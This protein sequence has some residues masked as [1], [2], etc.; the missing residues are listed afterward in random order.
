MARR[1]SIQIWFTPDVC[2]LT[3]TF[4]DWPWPKGWNIHQETASGL[5]HS[6][7][8][9]SSKSGYANWPQGRRVPDFHISTL[10]LSWDFLWSRRK[11]WPLSIQSL[12]INE[13]KKISYYVLFSLVCLGLKDKIPR[14]ELILVEKERLELSKKELPNSGLLRRLKNWRLSEELEELSQLTTVCMILEIME[15]IRRPPKFCLQ[16]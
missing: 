15:W 10:D 6:V 5:S 9:R 3:F 1:R 12:N 4:L 11:R 2:P 8:E 14:K 16:A 13:G 7:R